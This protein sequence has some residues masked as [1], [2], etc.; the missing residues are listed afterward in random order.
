[1]T[2]LNQVVNKALNVDRVRFSYGGQ[3]CLAGIDLQVDPGEIVCLLGPSGCGKTTLLRLVAGLEHVGSGSIQVGSSVV[4]TVQRHVP[5][6]SRPVGMV[7]QDFALF[8]HLDVR[9][10]IEFGLSHWSADERRSR[11]QDLLALTG[12]DG[13]GSR[14]PHTLSGGEQQRVALARALAPRPD[15]LLLDE[16]FSGLDAN[17]RTRV[18]RE[19]REL[20]RSSGTAALLVTHDADEAMQFADR[21]ALLAKGRLVQIGTPEE[22]YLR[23]FDPFVAEFFGELSVFDATVEGE[24]A[25]TPF[26]PVPVRGWKSAAKVRVLIR[27]EAVRLVSSTDESTASG[28]RFRVAESTLTQGRRRTLLC[29]DGQRDA[30]P[31]ARLIMRHDVREQVTVGEWV[32]ISL[33]PELVHVFGDSEDQTGATA[34]RPFR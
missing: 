19:T 16:P 34:S 23:P 11:L 13:Y 21:I 7:F 29:A 18:R 9:R 31:E 14:F 1:M 12:L 27:P 4:S 22:V 25:N 30:E 6:E 20:L 28:T 24:L 15:I 3:E 26:G 10:N 5:A 17:A 33:S 32:E 8:P 2:A